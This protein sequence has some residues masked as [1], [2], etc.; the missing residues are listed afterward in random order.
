MADVYC[1]MAVDR[2]GEDP[3][4][5]PVAFEDVDP[6]RAGL[7][8]EQSPSRLAK[9]LDIIQ[10]PGQ[11]RF[12]SC[13]SSVLE[14]PV[15]ED[16]PRREGRDGDVARGWPS[17]GRETASHVLAPPWRPVGFHHSRLSRTRRRSLLCLS[18]K[19]TRVSAARDR[20]GRPRRRR[21]G[22]LRRSGSKAAVQAMRRVTNETF[23]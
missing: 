21:D 13:T 9:A 19:T 11:D 8:R 6:R 3:R 10:K 18:S 16:L 7:A 17:D 22:L 1:G 23:G 14:V 2:P 15:P 4:V 12:P 20:R 5:V